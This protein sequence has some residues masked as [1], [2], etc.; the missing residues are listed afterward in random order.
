MIGPVESL[1][2]LEPCPRCRGP[3]DVIVAG[4]VVCQDQE[5]RMRRA[6]EAIRKV[7]LRLRR[8]GGRREARGV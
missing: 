7:G 3:V 4:V 5:C 1:H 2:P 8:R 6:I